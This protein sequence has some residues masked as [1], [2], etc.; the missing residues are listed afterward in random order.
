MNYF[1]ILGV[2]ENVTSD[3]AIIEAYNT[4][5]KKWQTILNQGIGEQAQIARRIMDG[6]LQDA[7]DTIIDPTK[8]QQYKRSLDLAREQG[9]GLGGD[10]GVQVK[11]SLGGGHGNYTF[12]VVENPVRYPLGE[13]QNIQIES[14]QEYVCRAWEDPDLGYETYSDRSLERW[15]HYS[16]GDTVLSEAVRYYKWKDYQKPAIGLMYQALDLLQT[17]YPVPILP[18]SQ[19]NLISDFDTIT[20]PQWE[21]SPSVVNLGLIPQEQI[22]MPVYVRYWKQNPGKLSVEVD[23]PVIQ[24]NTSKLNTEFSFLVEVNGSALKRGDIVRGKITLTSETYG[25][26]IIPVFGAR[27]KMMGNAGFAREIH[28]LVAQALEKTEDFDNASKAYRLAGAI[29]QS[30]QSELK[31]IREAY[32]CHQWTRVIDKARQFHNRYG[33][34]QETVKYL[35]EA[36][37]MVG[38][39]HYQLKQYERSLEYLASIA[40]EVGHLPGAKIPED[41]WTVSNDSQIQLNSNN[42]KADWVNVCE[43]LD[44]RWTHGGGNADQSKYA[45][46]MPINLKNRSIVWTT[47]TGNF[48]PPI[49]AYEGILVVRAKDNRSVVGLDAASGQVVWQ[50]TQGMT[51]REIAAPVAGNG[52]LFITDA[53]GV[54]YCLDV[55]KGT[56]KW[57]KQLKDSRDLSLA[58][59][60]NLLCVG[61]GTQVLFFSAEDG[62]EL[63]GTQEMKGFFGGGANPVNIIVT[64][65]CCL[66][67]KAVFR[68]QSMVFIDLDNGNSLE[69][70]IPYSLT[71]PVTWAA[72]EGEI[73]LPLLVTKEMR[74]KYRDS[75]GNMR[76][77]TEIVWDE[78]FFGVYGAKSDQILA[79]VETP[80]G[81]H[82]TQL[83]NGCDIYIKNVKSADVCAVAPIYT[84]KSGEITVI[85]PPQEG[86]YLH[87]MV[88]ASFGRDIY[89]WVSTEDSVSV[90]NFRRADSTVQSIIFADV[91]DMTVSSTTLST[92]LAGNTVDEHATEYVLPES[93]R[94][95]VGTPALYGDIIY[96]VSRS[97]QIAAI[98]R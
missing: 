41:S 53:N 8:R 6:E 66:Y 55:L 26:V 22:S 78:L 59:E 24:L 57:T 98:G 3:D 48:K 92:S 17:K 25:S 64:D 83:P 65:N 49:I 90:V 75:E 89:Y 38:A 82:P 42:P 54:L 13:Y 72:Y 81:T 74:C 69:Y 68:K 94:P 29:D 56:S 14:I 88:G 95:I 12:M 15:L 23:N 34:N 60:G 30:K 70:D 1:E 11:F 93:V 19:N 36:C 87:R 61:T 73:Y 46:P 50:H 76:E 63:A 58:I 79:A 32:R 67:Q 39:T 2:D 91:H 28:S 16:A 37:R 80:I 18:R 62:S 35:V 10:G 40:Y 5:Q 51:G 96:V 77:K 44:L 9:G 47:P 27:Y 52:S 84:E 86:K 71:P 21:I 85:Y 97:G 4:A 43:T 33:R 31:V 20:N 7:Y 45:G